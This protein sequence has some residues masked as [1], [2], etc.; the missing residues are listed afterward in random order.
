MMP[1]QIKVIDNLCLFIKWDDGDNS[2][3]KLVNLRRDCPC[4]I[5]N[6][7]REQKGGKYIPIYSGE[8]LKI[9]NI[10]MIG[11]YAVGIDWTDGHNTGI[12][13]FAI[14]KK[15]AIQ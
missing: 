4:A 9:K 10:H 2:S 7:E 15:M 13:D 5:C 3:I 6:S 1:L 14:L 12:Y 11:N 8:Q